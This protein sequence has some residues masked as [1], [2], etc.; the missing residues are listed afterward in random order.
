MT[1]KL[2]R[3][4]KWNNPYSME[5]VTVCGEE[6]FKGGSSMYFTRDTKEAEIFEAG[7][8]A[9]LK[10][11][12]EE[13]QAWQ[14]WAAGK[15]CKHSEARRYLMLVGGKGQREKVRTMPAWKE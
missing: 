12:W 7:A 2:W 1:E 5:K 3:P 6:L 8:N 10:V 4:K 11:I 13:H 15:I 9:M 14:R